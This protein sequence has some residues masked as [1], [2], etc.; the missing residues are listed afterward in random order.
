MGEKFMGEAGL[1]TMLCHNTS[2]KQKPTVRLESKQNLHNILTS[3]VLY[4]K[5]HLKKDVCP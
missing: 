4:I 1:K 2:L 5:I 3:C